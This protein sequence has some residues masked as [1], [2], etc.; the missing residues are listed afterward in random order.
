MQPL[1]PETISVPSSEK[2]TKF[3]DL[4]HVISISPDSSGGSSPPLPYFVIM[5]GR[6]YVLGSQYNTKISALG[7]LSKVLF[8]LCSL[9]IQF[10]MG[11]SARAPRLV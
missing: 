7:I 10:S 6:V 1:P 4:G 5:L 11:Y 8:S 9:V 3:T 2:A